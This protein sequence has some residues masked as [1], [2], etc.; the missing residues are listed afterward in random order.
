MRGFARVVVVSEEVPKSGD[1]LK[2]GLT[3]MGLASENTRLDDSQH[4]MESTYK[5]DAV[6][7]RLPEATPQNAGFEAFFALAN[8]LKTSPC[9]EQIPVIMIGSERAIAQCERVRGCVDDIMPLADLQE[10][11]P[12]RLRSALRL[13]TLCDEYV[14]RQLTLAEFGCTLDQTA[15]LPYAL[16]K[17][18]IASGQD[19]RSPFDHLSEQLGCKIAMCSVQALDRMV[20]EEEP[21]AIF[22]FPQQYIELAN[23]K[24][25]ALRLLREYSTL[26][27]VLLHPEGQPQVVFGAK[28]LPADIE[29]ASEKTPPANLM[30]MVLARGREHRLRRWLSADIRTLTHKSV[31]DTQTGL[32]TPAFFSRHVGRVI[33]DMQKGGSSLTLATFGLPPLPETIRPALLRQIGELISSQIRAED[34][35]ANFNDEV[36]CVAF[37]ATTPLDAIIALSRVER[38]LN[39]LMNTNKG[40]PHSQILASIIEHEQGENVL[41]LLARAQ[42]VMV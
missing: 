23:S 31:V 11:L 10:R 36:M 41:T 9:T 8:A 29:L 12:D 3:S 26:P 37:V 19:G 39:E 2:A 33:D 21:D 28:P 5:P 34:I 27:V 16:P 15:R 42:A 7:I 18:L 22:V 38:S 40:W 35:P 20:V 1:A 17:L 6:M 25:R 32:F 13:K 24:L 14:R 4:L 30:N